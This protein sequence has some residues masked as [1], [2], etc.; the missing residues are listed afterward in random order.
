VNV[1]TFWRTQVAGRHT[2]VRNLMRH[3]QVRATAGTAGVNIAVMLIGS[4]GGLFLA[5]ALGPTHRGDL[6]AILQ[7]PMMIGSVASLGITQSTCYWISRR[8]DKSIPLMSTAIAASLATGVVIA[9]L[10][11]WLAAV[12]GRN[13]EVR[14]DLAL[15]LALT[16]VYIAGGVWISTLQA[17]SIW[18][19]NLTRALQPLVY[20][21]AVVSLWALG[22]LTLITVV[23]AFAISVAGQALCAAI[24]ARRMIG[25]HTR[26]D[27]SLLG[28]LY[29]YGSKVWLSSVPQLVNVS[30]DQLVLSVIPSVAA[31]QLGNY[32]VAASLSWLALPA[33]TAFGS[34]A[35][36]RIARMAGAD[37]I[38]RIERISLVG[39]GL[40]AGL[41][42]GLICVVAPLVVPSLFGDGYRDAII[43]LWLLAPGTVFLALNR[44]L[45]DVLQGRGKPL[46]RSAGEGLG[47]IVTLALLLTLIPGFGIRGAAI[48]SSVT[49]AVVFFFLLLGLRR[50]RRQSEIEGAE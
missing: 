22:K 5:R 6:V 46:V 35:F 43:A 50:L 38:L 32:T 3:A 33:S 29:A 8:P 7:W 16:P 18:K 21:V 49:Y 25:R 4:V 19:W 27:L 20:L 31:A 28:P 12:I 9:A 26:P 44:V 40:I 1:S 48:A 2:D 10:G 36:P 11:P 13:A 37:A 41:T 24:V 15:V 47:A 42:I 34:V 14:S 45:G 17:T 23:A 39:A 30:V